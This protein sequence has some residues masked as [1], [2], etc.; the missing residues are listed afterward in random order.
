MSPRSAQR[1]AGQSRPRP[2]KKVRGQKDPRLDSEVCC[3]NSE[4]FFFLADAAFAGQRVC[5]CLE[6]KGRDLGFSLEGGVGSSLQNRPI[7]V[8]KIFQSESVHPKKKKRDPSAALLR[9][10]PLF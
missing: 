7:T 3:I 8:Q 5:V 1:Q 2:L 4:H 6:K 9:L 10:F